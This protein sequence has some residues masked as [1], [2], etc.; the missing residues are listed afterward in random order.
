MHNKH[1]YY[2]LNEIPLDNK[3]EKKVEAYW[4]EERLRPEDPWY[5]FISEYFFMCY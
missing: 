4:S 2:D 3:E 1:D 5:T